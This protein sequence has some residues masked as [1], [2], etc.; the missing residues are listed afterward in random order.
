MRY[1]F[2]ALLAPLL[3]SAQVVNKTDS[4]RISM[5][6]VVIDTGAR[7]SLKIF[8][9]TSADYRFR[10]RY[11]QTQIFDTVLT[12]DK[13]YRFSQFNNRDNFG[14]IAFANIGRPFN[15]L[16]YEYRPEF[17]LTLLP[18]GKS[19]NILAADDIKYYDV[20]TPTTAFVL[21]NGV[22]NGAALNTTYTQNIGKDFNFAIEYMGLRSQGMYRRE[23][24]ANNNTLFSAHYTAP[25]KRYEAFA[26]FLHQ[27]VNSEE[28]GGVMNLEDFLSGDSRFRDRQ[29]LQVNLNSSHSRFAYRRYYISHELGLIA[30]NNGYPLRLRH[31]L[32]EQ[33]NKYTYAQ[34]NPE[35]FYTSPLIEGFPLSTGKRSEDF[36]NTFSAVW[37]NERFK[38][39]AGVKYS[40]LSFRDNSVYNDAISAVEAYESKES[41]FGVQGN[42]QI[43]LW[44]KFRLRSFAEIS[45]GSKF[46]SYIRSDNR[47]DFNFLDE[48]SVQ[49]QLNFQ[50]AA[51]SFNYLANGSVY[52]DY[53]YIFDGFKNQSVLQAGGTVGLKW[54]DSR[55]F[56][57]YFI[58]D[59]YAYF[60]S[61]GQ[62]AQAGAPLNISQLGGEATFSYNK[63]HL[64]TRLL[65]QSALTEKQLLPMPAFVGRANIYWQSKAFKNAAEIQTGIKAYYFSK[66]ASRE[67]SSILNEFV[68]PGPAGYAIGGRPVLDA[69]FNLKVKTMTIFAEA[70]HFDAGI[71]KNRLFAAPYYP[72]GDFRLNLG[73]VWYLFH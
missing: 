33:L 55:A 67:F 40:F 62:P 73:I 1:I 21:H 60:S 3:F 41:R 11:G 2:F 14:R 70:Q 53:N 65:F 5:D 52:R 34:E 58:I 42:L 50:S 7:D 16:V 49:A 48:F 24:A 59:N 15:P 72:T 37:D 19:F 57:N 8:R 26:H 45:N 44:E 12:A 66:F 47:L 54:F 46:G 9:P 43:N 31:T 64:N 10:T 18:A 63:F 30:G 17:A 4:N 36:S 23:L 68:L 22:R 13:I 32:S 35:G 6:S 27:N 71:M 29:N 51:P 56:F 20:K 39:D 38:L 25:G 61:V 28:N 69:Y